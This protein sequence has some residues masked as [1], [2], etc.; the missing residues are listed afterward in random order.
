MNFR[1]DLNRSLGVALVG[2]CLLGGCTSERIPPP[3]SG[4]RYADRS[5]IV[6]GSKYVPTI[7]DLETVA[8]SLMARMRASSTFAAKCKTV[9]LKRAR[10]PLIVIGGLNN[11]TTLR[12]Q[13]RLDALVTTIRSE[14]Y[15]TSF[16][17]VKDDE[18][19][20]R[21]KRRIVL[22]ADGGLETGDLVQTLGEHDSPD[23]IVI[24]DLR[25]FEDDG[26]V[27][28]RLHLAVHSLATGKIAWEGV[29]TIEKF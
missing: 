1:Y 18:A 2:V 15:E 22:N 24:G 13:D 25:R 29:Q 21:I 5:A 23:F 17:E 28:H 14:L 10:H 20:E 11:F 3:V 26:I 12:I 9:E 8:R 4:T 16:I 7:H 6:A 19:A 27:S